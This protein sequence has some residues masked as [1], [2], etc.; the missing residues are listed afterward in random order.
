MR[1]GVD[2]GVHEVLDQLEVSVDVHQ[3][4]TPTDDRQVENEE[5]N[6][7]KCVHCGERV[8]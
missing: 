4:D 6:K 8:G 1:A 3:E 7:V 2:L 5:E